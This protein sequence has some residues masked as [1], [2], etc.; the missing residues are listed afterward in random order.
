MVLCATTNGG[1]I[2]VS[3]ALIGNLCGRVAII[4]SAFIRKCPVTSAFRDELIVYE[5][6][7]NSKTTA[8][9][10]LATKK[11]S[12]RN[13]QL[14]ISRLSGTKMFSTKYSVLFQ[15]FT[16]QPYENRWYLIKYITFYLG[17]TKISSN[18]DIIYSLSALSNTNQNRLSYNI[19]V[20]GESEIHKCKYFQGW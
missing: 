8:Q 1:G 6:Q 11:F 7:V 5:A 15:F 10:H 12:F 19:Y 18:I 9:I 2:W 4:S 16:V 13:F 3:M 14:R 20:Q 17:L